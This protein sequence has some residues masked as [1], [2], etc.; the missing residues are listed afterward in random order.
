MSN[1][2]FLHLKIWKKW[3]LLDVK[4]L[5][6]EVKWLLLEVKW[7]LLEVESLL[8]LVCWC[9]QLGQVSQPW[10][11]SS[12][13]LGQLPSL[14]S[15]V[16]TL[17]YKFYLNQAWKKDKLLLRLTWEDWHKEI[18]LSTF[19]EAMSIR[20]NKSA[21]IMKNENADIQQPYIQ[22]AFPFF[23]ALILLFR[24]SR[25][26]SL[27]KLAFL[28]MSKIKLKKYGLCLQLCNFRGCS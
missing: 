20:R 3:L 22:Q 17:I 5:L 2:E 28:G 21:E 4:W 12:H 18:N 25:F 9:G 1:F 10:L 26:G 6:L 16:A 27:D 11:T 23:D 14:T 8:H 15:P 19:L 7:L 24:R 13:W